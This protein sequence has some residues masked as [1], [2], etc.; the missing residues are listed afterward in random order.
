MTTATKI[1]GRVLMFCMLCALIFLL[2][3]IPAPAPGAENDTEQAP[4]SALEPWEQGVWRGITVAPESRC[5]AYNRRDYSYPP[6]VE[7]RIVDSMYGYV[8]G[9][10]TGRY[11]ESQR[12]TDIEHIVATAEAHDSGMCAATKEHRRA[13][14]RDLINLTLAAPKVNR[15]SQTGKCAKDATEWVP[16]HNKC[17][18]AGR[19][20]AVRQKYRLTIDRAEAEAL[21]A[22]LTR[23]VTTRMQFE[24]LPDWAWRA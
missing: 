1:A 5:S 15:C 17:W 21:E 24:L 20:V 23:C 13:F 3:K 12:E 16:E 2:T 4:T 8:Y 10:Y 14:A 18:F 19:V 6:S 22:I 11:F 9:P 7:N